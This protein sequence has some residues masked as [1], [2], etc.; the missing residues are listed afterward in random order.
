MDDPSNRVE[1][2]T[3]DEMTEAEPPASF[4]IITG[5]VEI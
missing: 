3:P 5:S 1:E 2:D 4:K